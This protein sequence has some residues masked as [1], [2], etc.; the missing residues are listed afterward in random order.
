MM[1]AEVTAEN[2]PA[3]DPSQYVRIRA[4]GKTHEYERRVQILVVSFVEFLVVFLGHLVVIFV[5]SR[6]DLL[7]GQAHVPLLAVGEVSVKSKRGM[8]QDLP[9]PR[10]PSFYHSF[11][12]L[13]F[14]P[15]VLA[16]FKH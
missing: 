12:L 5:E 13:R 8:G 2:R 9:I 1:K 7:R 14:S 3:C 16:T 15:R 6:T 11:F 10:F 4:T